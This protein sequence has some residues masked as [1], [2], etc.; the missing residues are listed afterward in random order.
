MIKHM[1][2]AAEEAGKNSLTYFRTDDIQTKL[3]VDH[4]DIVTVADV[5]SQRIIVDILTKALIEDGVP[6]E[7][8]GFIGEEQ[9]VKKGKHT[10]IIDPIDG[11]SNFATGLDYYCVSI[12]YAVDEVLTAGVVYHPISRTFFYAEKGKGAYKRVDGDDMKL[13][14]TDAPLSEKFL[15]TYLFEDDDLVKAVMTLQ[16]SARGMRS[17]GAGALDIC[18][19]ADNLF[20]VA[21]YLYMRLWDIAAAAVIVTEAGGVMYDWEGNELVFDFEDVNKKYYYIASHASYKEEVMKALTQ[22]KSV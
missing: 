9:L 12:G 3:K 7:E 20:G 22:V 14:V 19:V 4:Q 8:I 17:L 1:L 11:T 2:K 15:G 21:L 10:F 18:H 13:T 16:S 5:E 6:E